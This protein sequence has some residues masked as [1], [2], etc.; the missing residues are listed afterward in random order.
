MEVSA[1]ERERRM[2]YSINLRIFAGEKFATLSELVQYYMENSGQLREK[3]T[4]HVIELKQP[5]SC[6]IE[7]TTER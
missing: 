4:G 5:L 3:K 2:I 7:P 1:L 6:A